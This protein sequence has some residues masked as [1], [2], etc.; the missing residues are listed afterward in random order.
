[1]KIQDSLKIISDKKLL[2]LY[3]KFTTI[4][5]VSRR[6]NIPRNIIRDRLINLN[7]NTSKLRNNFDLNQIIEDYKTKSITQIARENKTST[8]KIIK[9]LNDAGIRTNKRVSFEEFVKKA[10]EIHEH[11]YTYIED[12]YKNTSEKT[13]VICPIHG[14]FQITPAH[15]TRRG[16]GC[17]KCGLNRR[18]S[19]RTS[20]IDQ[21]IEKAKKVHGET[22][23]YS[24]SVYKNS[25]IP[26]IIICKKHGEFLMAA[27]S[28]IDNGS[29]CPACARENS[30]LF[31]KTKYIDF[32][33]KKG[34]NPIIYLVKLF[35]DNEVFLKIGF[36]LE[37]LESRF[38]QTKKQY[39]FSEI[40]T[41][42]NNPEVIWDLEV[43][44]HRLC[45]K[46][47]YQPSLLFGGY[48]ECYKLE[49]LPEI[50]EI[51][52]RETA[53]LSEKQIAIP[54]QDIIT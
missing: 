48:T 4:S 10:N 26:L 9:L 47:K 25:K 35:N 18:A 45:K 1:M 50:L 8:D 3:K 29:G 11:K 39:L 28:H 52:N 7:I 27:N 21:F 37:K 13:S 6:I 54:I 51:W 33:K 38:R 31:K 12:G 42:M 30:Y 19:L 5:E 34:V 20:T 36:T 44:L 22:Y 16:Q 17:P 40:K 2:K 24:K 41:H 15:H 23:N 46:F 53:K 32:C 43:L 49:H 14:M